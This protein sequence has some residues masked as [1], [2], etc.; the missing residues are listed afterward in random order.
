[1]LGLWFKNEVGIKFEIKC[2]FSIDYARR[3]F[4]NRVLPSEHSKKEF[5]L[6]H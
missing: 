4:N 1:M 3:I 6:I 2:Q 5:L